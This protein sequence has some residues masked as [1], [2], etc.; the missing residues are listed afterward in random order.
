MLSKLIKRNN[1][2]FDLL[3]RFCMKYEYK[4]KP[5]EAGQIALI[6]VHSFGKWVSCVYKFSPTEDS[7]EWVAV[8]GHI[9]EEKIEFI[10]KNILTETPVIPG[11]VERITDGQLVIFGKQDR[12][13]GTSDLD[14]QQVFM[15]DVA[16]ID[17]S[18]GMY[19]PKLG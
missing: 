12:L 3:E 13:L 8:L 17:K 7:Y 16:R 11:V 15:D 9:P 1:R 2:L 6:A 14:I 18:F 4:F 5:I 19:K 10:S